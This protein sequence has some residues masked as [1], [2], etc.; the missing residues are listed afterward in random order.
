MPAQSYQLAE[1]HDSSNGQFHS[2][3]LSQ[4]LP[5]VFATGGE[6]DVNLYSVEAEL[7]GQFKAKRIIGH[8]FKNINS[9]NKKFKNKVN[10]LLCSYKATNNQSPQLLSATPTVAPTANKFKFSHQVPFLEVSGHGIL[11]WVEPTAN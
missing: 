10:D 9:E 1:V 5:S 7:G 6:K 3:V 4:S 2:A 11:K 8:F